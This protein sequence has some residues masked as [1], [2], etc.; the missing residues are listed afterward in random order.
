MTAP[1]AGRAGPRDPGGPSAFESL[2]ETFAHR[3]DQGERPRAE[4]YLADLADPGGAGGPGG[5]TSTSTGPALERA[6]DLIYLE[7]CLAEAAG[8]APDPAAYL[9]RFPACRDRLERLLGLHTAIDA[10]TLRRWAADGAGPGGPELPEAG[11]QLGPFVLRRELGRGGFGRVFLA[12]Q[13]DLADRLV[14]LKV[15]TRA[16]A[17][18]QLLARVRH[19]HIVEVIR[20]AQTADDRLHLICMPFWGGASLAAVLDA[21]WPATGAR[22]PRHGRALVAALDRCGAPEFVRDDRGAI[23]ERLRRGSYA[24]AIAW[25]VA[26][27]AEAIEHAHRR[28]VS[29]GD[30]K[31]SNVLIAA[32]GRPMLL[33]FGLAVAWH[34][35]PAACGREGG[36]PLYM[37][38]ER[39]RALAEPGVA[40]R[41]PS[42]R[43]RHRADLYSLG[44]LLREA[45]TGERPGLPPVHRQLAPAEL[46]R[47]L[48][49]ERTQ[50]PNRLSPRHR[51][52]PPGLRPI[53]DRALAPDPTDRYSSAVQMAEDLD[54]WLA[55]RPLPHA[56]EPAWPHR[57]ARWARRHRRPLGVAALLLLALVGAGLLTA[58]RARSQAQRQARA[59]LEQLFGGR[60][61]GV[62]RFRPFGYW[63]PVDL[64]EPA[65]MAVIHLS[66]YGLIGTGPETDQPQGP[67]WRS[68]SDVASLPGAEAADLELWLLEQAWRLARTLA[69]RP[70]A[71]SDWRRALVLLERDAAWA[72]LGP[73]AALRTELRQR[74]ALPGPSLDPERTAPQPRLARFLQALVD[75]PERAEDALLGFEAVAGS[76]PGAFWPHYRAAAVA[77]R[78]LD[79]DRAVSHLR[80]CL[81][82]RPGCAPLHAQLSACLYQR[83]RLR[84]VGPELGQ[85]LAEAEQAIALDSELAEAYRCRSYARFQLG[86]AEGGE[87]DLTR[88]ALLQNAR[89]PSAGFELRLQLQRLLSQFRLQDPE[90][91]A[92]SAIDRVPPDIDAT[93]RTLL[94]SELFEFGRTGEAFRQLDLALEREPDNLTTLYVRAMRRLQQGEPDR[95]ALDFEPIANSLRFDELLGVMPQAVLSLYCLAQH[96]LAQGDPF[97]ALARADQG[98]SLAH[99]YRVDAGPLHYVLA[100]VHAALAVTTPGHR[101]QVI[102]HLVAAS[103]TGLPEALTTASADPMLAPWL[104]G[105]RP[106]PSP[107]SHRHARGGQP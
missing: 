49:H 63:K 14:V 71:P 102:A 80:A 68:R 22:P 39:L 10:D 87:A 36:T 60:E 48:A 8:L 72:E 86:Q 7:F 91:S 57:L 30:L 104:D 44:L 67:A 99:R 27:L 59:A 21:L 90:G 95:A 2:L 93:T 46:A 42:P 45:L 77:Y 105:L 64:D 38:P 76:S 97:R 50:S 66:R 25:Q 92:G 65:R 62:Y 37:A 107:D 28:G 70:D 54:A 23:R 58:Q 12:E 1:A 98:L 101:D 94:A 32:D 79:Y 84:S 51:A 18:P 9:E 11:D 78:R 69:D 82:R 26:R 96:H 73:I 16:S 5:A 75:E 89:H 40:S 15:T 88:F 34:A 47:T 24:R 81:R 31:P 13:A 100:Q 41:P 29:H 6:L 35:G 103:A 53:L 55:D 43:A 85:A 17:E 52:I 74:L 61:P 4:E 106:V 19:P 33:D 3:W 56:D 20:H 83:G